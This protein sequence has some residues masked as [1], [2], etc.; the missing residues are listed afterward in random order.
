MSEYFATM[1]YG[2]NILELGAYP[3]QFFDKVQD[4]EDDFKDF[5]NTPSKKNP[6]EFFDG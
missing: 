5:I 1:P 3:Y 6:A 4:F 2:E